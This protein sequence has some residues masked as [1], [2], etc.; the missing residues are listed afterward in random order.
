MDVK[1]L[2]VVAVL[3]IV[4]YSPPSEAKPISLVERCYCRATVNSLPKGYIR[5]LRFIHTPHCPFQVIAKLKSGKEVCLN[6]EMPWLQHYLKNAI[7]K[8]KKSMQ[9]N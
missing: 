2:T 1:L 9:A 5:E 7:R 8:M 4:I 6:P 3:I